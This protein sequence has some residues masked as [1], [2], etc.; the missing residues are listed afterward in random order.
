MLATTV[1]HA[2]VVTSQVGNA[3]ACRSEKSHLHQLGWWSNP[4]LIAA[5]G[6]ELALILIMVYLPPLARV[7][8]HYPLPPCYVG[9]VVPDMLRG[10]TV[11]K[12]CGKCWQI[13]YKKEQ[14]LIL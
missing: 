6:I 8:S 12:D 2:G 13:N 3:F 14:H 10:C 5:I 1:Y 11:W 4:L 7:F 9:G